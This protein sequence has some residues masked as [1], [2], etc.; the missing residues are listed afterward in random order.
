MTGPTAATP[1]N[2]Q[3]TVVACWRALAATSPGAM[4]VVT[5]HSVVAVFPS[6]APWNNAI[7]LSP[8]NVDLAAEVVRVS[9][10]YHRAQVSSWAFWV[11]SPAM[12][13]NEPDEITK[14]PGLKRDATTLVMQASAGETRALWDA[15]RP[16]SIAD[17]I[18]ATDEPIPTSELDGIDTDSRL[19]AGWVV[20]D[21][22]V[23]VAGAYRYLHGT[24]CGIYAV[25][26]APDWRRRGIGKRLVAHIMADAARHG[27]RTATLQ[28]VPAARR[29]YEWLGFEAVGRYEEWVPA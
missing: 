22:E 15:A 8:H 2:G 6:F 1:L 4:L 29:M 11:P 7:V 17:A 28:S 18:R 12:S 27:A 3:E 13:L 20:L 21:D 26:T 16:A 24:D 10:V 14:V 25:G 9:D 23:A 5:P 19:L